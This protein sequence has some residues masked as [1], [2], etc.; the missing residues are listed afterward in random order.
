MGS[1]VGPNPAAVFLHAY[2]VHSQTVATEIFDGLLNIQAIGTGT[3]MVQNNV[4]DAPFSLSY[5]QANGFTFQSNYF[6]DVMQIS[7]SQP[8]ASFQGNFYHEPSNSKLGVTIQLAGGTNSNYWVMDD[9]VN[10][11]NHGPAEYPGA[12]TTVNGD[13]VDQTG[14]N[15]GSTS[16]WWITGSGI[17]AAANYSILNTIL[18]PNGVGQQGSWLAVLVNLTAGMTVT[19]EHNTWPVNN[20]PGTGGAVLTRHPTTTP[21]PAGM[22][23]SY[24][25]NIL[26][27]WD[28]TNDYYKLFEYPGQGYQTSNGNPNNV[29]DP[30]ACDYND[31]YNTLTDGM[32][33]SGGGNGYADFFT[34]TPGQHD[35]AV[36]PMFKDAT[37]NM[38]TF[39]S[40]YLHN[41]AP[42]WN[43]SAGIGYYSVGQMVS[44]NDPTLYG[45]VAL[46]FPATGAVINYRYTNGSSSSY[47]G[48]ATC[49]GANPKPGLY[50]ALSRA[51]WEWATLYDIRQNLSLIA[52]L[53]TWVHDGYAPRNMV[54]ATSGYAGTYI[55]AVQP[56]SMP[57]GFRSGVLKKGEIR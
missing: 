10:Y 44:S 26:W 8:W 51:C 13:I 35:L 34:N 3:R 32:G 15:T 54:L 25:S 56:I 36:N 55:G 46:G 18:L 42:A 33:F 24:R 4:F 49:S 12:G 17:P 11:N 50:T 9:P 43:A 20:L 22:L 41:T 37:R 16:C 47:V 5:F 1:L 40:A 28:T 7:G 19:V 23:T 45:T 57:A 27:N 31:G 39:D 21:T 38:A 6:G 53:M 14:T 30:A 52:T 29:C 48:S 2:N